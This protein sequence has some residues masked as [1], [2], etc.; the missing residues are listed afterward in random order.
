M[1]IQFRSALGRTILT[2]ATA[3]PFG[4]CALGQP[5]PEGGTG[6][7]SSVAPALA[8]KPSPPAG[9]NEPGRPDDRAGA[10]REGTSITK[11]TQVVVGE[12]SGW[13][14]HPHAEATSSLASPF[15]PGEVLAAVGSGKVKRFAPNGT[16]I[17][18]LDTADPSGGARNTTGMAVDGLN[19]LYVTLFTENTAPQSGTVY[20]FDSSGRLLGS[21]G[22]SYNA[23]PE[24]IVLDA[25]GNI[26][27][28]QADG[29]RK[30]LKFS[31]QAIAL[32]AFSP[33][34]EKRGLDWI[35]L[36]S[37]QRTLY[38]TSEGTGVKRYDLQSKTQL[39]DF[40]R[41]PLPGTSAYALRILPSGGVLV[42]DSEFV[43]RLD[44][45]GY[46]VQRYDAPG[47]DS[48]FAINLDPDGSS[49]WSGNYTTGKV[50]RF[51]IASGDLL[52]SWHSAPYTILA[53]LA[54]VKERTAAVC[55]VTCTATVAA[56][57]NVG[58]LV[59]FAAIATP[60][61]CVDPIAWAW[62]FGDGGTSTLQS[63]SHV[64]SAAGSYRWTVTATSGTATCQ[65][66]G[67]IVVGAAQE[68]SWVLTSGP[69]DASQVTVNGAGDVFV[70]T[71]ASGVWRS[72]DGG[73]SWTQRISGLPS[74]STGVIHATADGSL[75]AGAHLTGLF[76]STSRGDSWTATGQTARKTQT[77]IFSVPGT[78]FVADGFWCTGVYR[79][80][81]DGGS[82]TQVNT[83]LDG[84]VNGLARNEAGTLIAATGTTG[85][86][87]SVNDGASWVVSNS[88]MPA[89]NLHAATSN[90]TGTLFVSSHTGAGV[91]RSVDNGLVWLASN[92]GLPT[93]DISALASDGQLTML[94]GAEG[95][96]GIFRSTDGGISWRALNGGL[97]T[98]NRG[99]VSS[100]AFGS[101]G[102]AYAV[103]GGKV[104][105]TEVSEL[106]AP[107]SV[108]IEAIDEA[109]TPGLLSFRPGDVLSLYFSVKDGAGEL[110][111]SSRI[112]YTPTLTAATQIASGAFTWSMPSKGL[113]RLEI[114]GDALL[115]DPQGGRLGFPAGSNAVWIDGNACTVSS[116]PAAVDI[117]RLPGP[118]VDSW[119]LYAEGSAGASGELGAYGIKGGP[120]VASL[121]AAKLSVGGSAGMGL[122]IDLE[123]DGSLTLSRRLA[124]SATAELKV[125]SIEAKVTRVVD[126]TGPGVS[127][128]A[129]AGFQGG[130]VYRYAGSDPL[131]DEARL[132]NA[133]FFLE[134][135]TL[136]G[137][138]G[139]PLAGVLV[140]AIVTTLNNRSGASAQIA[141]GTR[142]VF[143]DATVGGRVQAN[144]GEI[145]LSAA[146][147]NG[148][149]TTLMRGTAP[150]FAGEAS[151]GLRSALLF[152]PTSAGATFVGRRNEGRF[153]HAG[154]ATLLDFQTLWASV[155]LG[156]TASRSSELSM[157]VERD[158][159]DGMQELG[160]G[161]SFQTDSRIGLSFFRSTDFRR[162]DVRFHFENATILEAL[163]GEAS[164]GIGALLGSS[165]SAVNL[166]PES[167]RSTLQHDV[168][169]AQAIAATGPTAFSVELDEVSG[170]V[171][172][173][174]L[175]LGFGGALGVGAA[176]DLGL[177]L[178]YERSRAVPN[179]RRIARA[180]GR[181]WELGRNPGMPSWTDGPD[182]ADLLEERVVSGVG[183]LVSTAMS[184]LVGG[185]KKWFS[186]LLT[187][188]RVGALA[189]A[190]VVVVD[191]VTG[192]AGG[193]L[194]VPDGYRT[195]W[196][197]LRTGDPSRPEPEGGSS[198]T[199]QGIVTSVR[200]SYS[201]EAV[202]RSGARALAPAERERLELVGNFVDI[203]MGQA[204]G[205]AVVSLPAAV[206]LSLPI[207]VDQMTAMGVSQVRASDVR[208][209]RWNGV[210]R[211]WE[212]VGGTV[213]SGATAVDASVRQTGIYAPGVLTAI[214]SGDT[215]GDG[216]LDS[217]EDLDGDGILDP[218]ES[219][220]YSWDTDGDGVSDSG[221]RTAGTDPR[222]ASSVPNRP[223]VLGFL[224]N[225]VVR[226][227]KT[228]QLQL[229]ALDPDGNALEYSASGL[230]AGASLGPASGLLSFTPSQLGRWSVTLVVR[231]RPSTG[232][233]LS[234][235]QTIL[236]ES[237]PV[238]AADDDLASLSRAVPIVLDSSGAGGSHYT[239]ELVLTNR[240]AS[241]AAV[242]YRFQASLGTKEGSGAVGETLPAGTQKSIPNVIEYLR[243]L[244][245]A[246]PGPGPSSPQG[247]A[248]VVK[249]SGAESEDVVSAIART[250][251]ATSAPQPVGAAGLA[252]AGLPPASTTATALTIY[253]L[254]QNATDR[255]N[256]A[257]FNPSPHPVTVRV[258]AY[259]GDGS[260]YFRVI[261]DAETIGGFGWVQYSSV[262]ANASIT[263]GWVVVEK[264]G[265][266]G[267]FSA[268]GV[269]ND[270]GTS[271]GSFVPPT[272]GSFAG[273]RLTVPVLVEAG[274]FRSELVL[275]SRSSASVTLTLSYVESASPQYGAGGT[276]TV[277]LRPKEQKVVP[278]A[279]EYLRRNGISLGASGTSS[280]V[281]ML[282][283]TVS[284]ASLSD[285]FAG[286]R[287]ASQS[288]A[289]GQFGLFT[290]CVYEG[291]EATSEA[292]LY[293][294]LADSLNRSNVA[295]LNAGPN[296]AGSVSLEIRTFDGDLGGLE[297]GDPVRVSLASGQWT[298]YTN[299]LK[300]RG[301]RNG[302]VKVART[303]GA[304]PWIAYGVVNDGAN[305][306]ERTGDGAYVPMT[307][308]TDTMPP[309]IGNELTFMLPGGVPL[310]MV[311]IPAGT[312]QM[313]SPATERNRNPDETP[314]SVTL[315]NDFYIGRH[316][317]T[318][319]QWQAVMG[320]NPS[321]FQACGGSCPVEQVSWD[322]IRGPSGF[323]EKLNS[324][325]GTT[326][327][328]LPTEAEWER[329]A[330][331]G[332]QARFSFGDS[333]GGDDTCGANAEASP[334]VWWCGT[335]G[336]TTHPVGTK[337]V[338]PYGL[339]DVNGN[340][341]EWV[342]DRYS[343][344]PT[345]AVTD[346]SGPS[347]GSFHVYRGGTWGSNLRFC[348]AAYR[349]FGDSSGRGYAIGFRLGMSQ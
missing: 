245:L 205:T 210:S 229:R 224:S 71:Q 104:Y 274:G 121:A 40:N 294:L 105:R 14:P 16:L 22:T 344:Y 332:S 117:A 13:K 190:E 218:G 292:Y 293:G 189:T 84:C 219:S 141:K 172:D 223:P 163:K 321:Y 192:R 167:I 349:D 325:L 313:G 312:F 24:S 271:D 277:T 171:R 165:G 102:R 273:N 41:A 311:R 260:G 226:V 307:I 214:V 241:P 20:K 3:M 282:R 145:G 39:S 54:V 25:T 52:T 348:R 15:A 19:N 178:S 130:Q 29:L 259:S 7:P 278:D 12:T 326:K 196:A 316:E 129:E 79:S 191:P 157:W 70:G 99:S 66:S 298:Q 246:I 91:Y 194:S 251:T 281:G 335:S 23:H 18:I 120:V 303:A 61:G 101:A 211:A 232:S 154:T 330:R 45:D 98:T 328:R 114:L 235:S 285:V 113:A 95:G 290:P 63:S 317:V 81:N 202:L 36:A 5:A 304:A 109:R 269:I 87:R 257:V 181:T 144:L 222:T 342:E 250:T 236:I 134:T 237:Q 336:G 216:L 86:Y 280:F 138:V 300:D 8:A 230:P 186:D 74:L 252:Y 247:G 143:T 347:W 112:A 153:A 68:G 261:R 124:F 319:A 221:E 254:R 126:V 329:A 162:T 220:P 135:A 238:L 180:G 50:Y 209:F 72:T 93:G 322:D 140:K 155:D 289:E 208:V 288:P 151:F 217:E 283:V 228:L 31:P 75:F 275:A 59:N 158:P 267:S 338:N 128:A 272:A 78:V 323:V 234:D 64:F 231:D 67:T 333:L 51:D 149:E 341:S 156:L 263:Q 244:G 76:K 306:G 291:Q 88:G 253:G 47:E 28:G 37:D 97:P 94:A 34:T 179:A 279:I 200:W 345:T 148:L 302:W 169:R 103:V 58:S 314:H 108:K 265:G 215:D 331:G 6:R 168:D 203:K 85:V 89:R 35:D 152:E 136:G 118:F 201:T 11:R 48:W 132:S 122:S 80:R 239:T 133:G 9:P 123:A 310:T 339:H 159:H 164:S 56:N 30:V 38:Y 183:P 305:P 43:V 268:Y 49:F 262:L 197:E 170:R 111:G 147:K 195:W 62:D 309:T 173:V 107:S 42:A 161:G 240:G 258:T 92:S 137:L 65:K 264:T 212:V 131:S 77:T 17:Q 57:G 270:N 177:E 308:R 139:S 188:N 334:H 82:W 242:T 295:I 249:F 90:A 73:A 324:L 119:D 55:S 96:E 301:I 60:S 115:I 100:L 204:D 198:S 110:V 160:F 227:G 315:T 69:T 53:G 150:S 286:A 225:Q 343:A 287:T 284:G 116:G 340:V 106:P 337:S 10:L 175:D 297:R 27:V 125:P 199:S 318:Q 127:A 193:S 46:A 299:F 146:S 266:S 243:G 276:A 21:F 26:L 1:T 207:Y 174:E 166:V 233:S 187:W 185:V 248:V 33:Q 2:I 182:L 296:G 44:S 176:L 4:L 327:F 184:R 320:S 206:S 255:S 213:R 256:V 32:D 346:P 142:E 83:G